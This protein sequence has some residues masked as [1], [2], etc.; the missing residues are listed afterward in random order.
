MAVRPSASRPAR[1]V[2]ADPVELGIVP[3]R[4]AALVAR[5]RREIDDGLLPSCQLALARHGRLAAHVALGDATTDTRYVVFSCTKAMTAGMAWLLIGEGIL[6][7]STRAAELIPEFGTNGKDVVTLEHLLTH[8]AGFPNAPL[9]PPDWFTR[10]GRRARFAR[11][12]LDWAPGTAYT[13]HPSAAH[14]VVADMVEQAAG[15]DYRRFFA[16]RVAGPLGLPR[17]QLGVAEVDQRDVAILEIRGEPATAAEL[18]AALGVAELPVTEVTDAALVGFNDPRVRALG[19]PGGGAVTTTADLALYYQALLHDAGGL[20]DPG[21]LADGTRNV[22]VRLPD[23]LL[24]M[25]ALR[26]LGLVVAGDD[27]RSSLRGFGKT[28]SPRTFGHAGA[29]GQIAWADP[30]TG[31]SFAYA[32]NGVDANQLRH[33]RRGVALSSLAALC[34]EPIS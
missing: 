14:W 7:P 16:E 29:A 17:M 18:A 33:A 25:P 34:T 3:E 19:V 22:R 10:E 13:Y 6:A 1:T 24:G 26:T 21:V 27:G 5:A 8:T 20:W 15:T 31:L 12:R 30:D 2:V 28:C 4:L 9:G 32:T 11:W 23:P